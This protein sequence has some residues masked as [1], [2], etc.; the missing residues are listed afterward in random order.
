MTGKQL[1]IEG[2]ANIKS[3]M[4]KLLRLKFFAPESNT[5]GNLTVNQPPLHFLLTSLPPTPVLRY[6]LK[7]CCPR[8]LLSVYVGS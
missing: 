5:T 3:V 7:L 8:F 1:S 2:K 4:L 6:L